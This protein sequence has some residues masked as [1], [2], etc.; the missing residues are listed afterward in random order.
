MNQNSHRVVALIREMVGFSPPF[1]LPFTLPFF[2]FVIL[3]EA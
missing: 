3:S 1:T 2:P